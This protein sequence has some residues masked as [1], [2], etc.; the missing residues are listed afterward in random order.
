MFCNLSPKSN[1]MVKNAPFM[2]VILVFEQRKLMKKHLNNRKKTTISRYMLAQGTAASNSNLFHQNFLDVKKQPLKINWNRW[3]V[4]TNHRRFPSLQSWFMA[5]LVKIKF[6]IAILWPLIRDEV[7]G[8]TTMVRV[9]LLQQ[10]DHLQA[11]KILHSW[12]FH[13]CNVVDPGQSSD[14]FLITYLNK[15]K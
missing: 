12:N 3:L 9:A 13:L 1:S 5:E 2:G 7:Q 10:T 8:W 14:S 11:C 4:K 15:R 6:S